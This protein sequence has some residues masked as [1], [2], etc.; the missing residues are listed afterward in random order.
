MVDSEHP[1]LCYMLECSD[2]SL[3]VGAA[4]NPAQRAKRHNWG[5]GSRHTALRRPVKLVWQEQHASEGS[6][7]SREAELKGWRREKKLELI[8]GLRREIHPSP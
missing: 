2:G 5:A 6:A 3:Y 4:K 1:W 8:A 7:R